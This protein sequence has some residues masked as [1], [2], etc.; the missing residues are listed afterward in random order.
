MNGHVVSG[1]ALQPR[2]C[3]VTYFTLLHAGNSSRFLS[4]ADFFFNEV[5]FFFQTKKVQE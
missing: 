3:R 2:A 5:G 4:S 1:I